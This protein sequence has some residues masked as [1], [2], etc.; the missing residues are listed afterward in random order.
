M[1]EFRRNPVERAIIAA[2]RWL[3]VAL[4]LLM[5]LWAASGIV[6]LYVAFP[7]LTD[8][9]RLAGL[10]SLE[11]ND[12][13]APGLNVLASDSREIEVS[14]LAGRVVA[15]A[16]GPDGSRNS[17]DL[18]RGTQLEDVTPAV[19]GAVA[20]AHL[21][22]RGRKGSVSSIDQIHND[23][24]T[25]YGRFNAHRPL[26]KV[27][28]DSARG[29]VLY[30]SGRTGQVVQDTESRER[31]WNWL[32]AVPHWLYYTTFREQQGLWYQ[33]IVYTSLLGSVLVGSG[34][35]LGI[36]R[37]L[38]AGGRWT[39]Y[40]GPMRWHHLTGLA[41]GL[42]TFTWV[43]SGLF[44]MNPWGWFESR[45]ASAELE[46]VESVDPTAPQIDAVLQAAREIPLDGIVSL[47]LVADAKSPTIIAT[48][49]DGE[50]ARLR[51]PA[52]TNDPIARE[53]LIARLRTMR[54]DASLHSLE[55][56]ETEDAYYFGHKT[57]VALP[58]YRAI[59]DDDEAT[60][61]YFH[62]ST[63]ELLARI[64]RP[65]KLYRWL[66]HGLH[67]LEFTAALR[68]RPVW[69]IVIL[70]LLAGVTFVCVIGSWVGYRRLSYGRRAGQQ[71]TFGLRRGERSRPNRLSATGVIGSDSKQA[72]VK[73]GRA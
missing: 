2:H 67:R 28:F 60:R 68:S 30:V 25:V 62:G 23:Q 33:F 47:R 59:L 39:R 34:M 32:G 56:I 18:E 71:R 6:M 3:G 21:A 15:H 5:T 61:Y 11:L 40:L 9:E 24:W 57:K 43:L 66:H 48:A 13:C 58:A 22:A 26:Y 38:M 37:T 35:Y 53:E 63:G 69:D 72:G 17:F 54:P 50:R 4:A 55:L 65:A 29:D 52:L 12:C 16:T 20:S 42:F 70:P 31:F 8:E 1:P 41:C 36:K 49:S 44:S 10:E 27:S 7:E 46:R 45:G 64:D 14:M 19:A 73:G 51:G